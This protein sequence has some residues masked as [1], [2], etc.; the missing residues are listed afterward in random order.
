[1]TARFVG[2]DLGLEKVLQSGKYANGKCFYKIRI[3]SLLYLFRQVYARCAWY[4]SYR[5]VNEIYSLELQRLCESLSPLDIRENGFWV[6]IRLEIKGTDGDFLFYEDA[7]EADCSDYKTNQ[8]VAP[9]GH[10]SED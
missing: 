9:N 6:N 2:Y 3:K 1:M 4:K 8:G 10:S 5:L 7:Q